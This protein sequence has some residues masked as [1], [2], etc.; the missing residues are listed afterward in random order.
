MWTTG[1]PDEAVLAQ[2]RSA[3]KAWLA[4]DEYE[5]EGPAAFD[6]LGEITAPSVLLIGDKDYPPLIECDEA[7]VARI[8]GCRKIDV[9]GGDHLL[10]LR[11]PELVAETIEVLAG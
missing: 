6:R 8:P 9:P 4:N 7:I 1:Q 3:A 11:F 10:P 2:L 5:K